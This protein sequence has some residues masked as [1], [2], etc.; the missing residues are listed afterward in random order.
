[1]MWHFTCLRLTWLLMVLAKHN[2]LIKIMFNIGIFLLTRGVQRNAFIVKSCR[3][4]LSFLSLLLE[5]SV[6][7]L[8]YYN[9]LRL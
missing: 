5:A 8:I 4:N 9:L 1:M 2:V 3:A 7:Y 6:H